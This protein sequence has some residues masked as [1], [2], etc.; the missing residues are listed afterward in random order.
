MKI[1][2]LTGGTG[3]GKSTAARRFEE[4]G[5]PVIDADRIGHELIAPGGAAEAAVVAAFGED[6]VESGTID[7][8][9]LG[10]KVFA[11]DDARLKLNAIVHPAL[12]AEIARRAMAHAE[13]GAQAVLVDAALLAENGS[14]D[15]WL[16]GLV[17][18]DAPVDVRV[19][20]LREGRGIDEAESRRRIAAQTDPES[21]RA[22]ADWIIDNG[23]GLEALYAQVDAVAEAIS[24]NADGV[25]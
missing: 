11:S 7:R 22:A 19:R 21:K 4:K 14:K 8:A 16:A 23:G 24:G 2:G 12:F 9:R 1:I 6:I 20:R 18:V 15:P 17:L 13:A 25:S 3:S 5:I 10:A